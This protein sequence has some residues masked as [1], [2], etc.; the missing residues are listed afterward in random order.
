MKLHK[1]IRWIQEHLFTERMRPT[2]VPITEL[3]PD[4]PLNIFNKCLAARENRNAG[5]VQDQ[6]RIDPPEQH[7]SRVQQDDSF[8]VGSRCSPEWIFPGFGNW[9]SFAHH[10]SRGDD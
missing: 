10:E 5:R 4:T 6:E 3:S 8:G 7:Q 9:H 1:L 2:E